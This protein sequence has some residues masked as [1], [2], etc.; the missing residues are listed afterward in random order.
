MMRI[1][2]LLVDVWT[3]AMNASLAQLPDNA[4][5]DEIAV[6]RFVAG[7]QPEHS[8]S[9]A[10][11]LALWIELFPNLCLGASSLPSGVFSV[12]L[13]SRDCQIVHRKDIGASF[14]QRPA[15]ALLPA[16]VAA[17]PA[18]SGPPSD[19]C[20]RGS[21]RLDSPCGPRPLPL[22]DERGQQDRLYPRETCGLHTL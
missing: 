16:S 21:R 7:G 8:F 11:E 6:R 20:S 18:M 13:A 14:L 22:G 2:P 3:V 9:S 12:C 15:V 4:S 10:E 5:P 19:E 17:H 1:S